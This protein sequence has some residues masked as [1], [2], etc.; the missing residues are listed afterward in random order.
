MADEL[1]QALGDNSEL[2]PNWKAR[3]PTK[4]PAYNLGAWYWQQTESEQPEPPGLVGG[5]L[6]RGSLT[7][8]ADL[9]ATGVLL[10]QGFGLD[11]ISEGF[12]EKAREWQEAASLIPRRVARIEDVKSAGDL[13]VFAAESIVETLPLL[14]SVLIPGGIVGKL[15]GKVA[16]YAAAGLSDVGIH[17]G[18]SALIAQEAGESPAD[19]RVIGSGVGKAALDFIPIIAVLKKLGV[20]AVFDKHITKELWNRGYWKRAAGTAGTIVATE[21]PTE[22]M[23]E[24]IN[25]SLNRSLRDL[26]GQ[27]TAEEK[28]QLLNAGAAAASMGLLGLPLG[29]IRP[30]DQ[31]PNTPDS[32]PPSGTP[33][34]PPPWSAGGGTV[35]DL[36]RTLYET[37]TGRELG[38]QLQADI[39]ARDRAQEIDD[40]VY[41]YLYRA[42]RD[43]DDGSGPGGGFAYSPSEQEA[44]VALEKVRRLMAQG[45]VAQAQLVEQAAK[46]PASV[47]PEELAVTK[48]R[49]EG[50]DE[51]VYGASSNPL[52]F[53][54]RR[55]DIEEGGAHFSLSGGSTYFDPESVDAGYYDLR[56]ANVANT[57]DP[58][59][60][61]RI[62]ER[63]IQNETDVDMLGDLLTELEQL[64]TTREAV[65]T[66]EDMGPDSVLVQ[67][68]KDLGYDGAQF[69][70]NDD[71]P[72]DA[73]TVN[74]WNTKTVR[75]LQPPG[76]DPKEPTLHLDVDY[77]MSEDAGVVHS[78][79]TISST[80][81]GFLL[82]VDGQEAAVTP[83][84]LAAQQLG[85][86]LVDQPVVLKYGD[87]DA[88]AAETTPMEREAQLLKTNGAGPEGQKIIAIDAAHQKTKRPRATKPRK[89][90]TV[91]HD[92]DFDSLV[93]LHAEI[94]A[95]EKS[96]RN[97][98][99][100]KKTVVRQLDNIEARA[101]RLAEVKK[102]PNPLAGAKRQTPEQAEQTRAHSGNL[103]TAEQARL[104]QLYEWEQVRGLSPREYEAL[105]ELIAKRDGEVVAER[106]PATEEAVAEL[107]QDIEAAMLQAEDAFLA[108]LDADM[109]AVGSLDS[110]A[111][112]KP[113]ALED[114]LKVLKAFRGVFKQAPNIILV[115]NVKEFLKRGFKINLSVDTSNMED[116]LL[117]GLYKNG[118]VYIFYGNMR[119]AV[120]MARVLLHETVAHYG[121]RATMSSSDMQGLLDL[122][123]RTRDQDL[124]TWRSNQYL[125]P[126]E[127]NITRAEAEEYIAHLAETDR[128]LSL[129][130]KIVA[131]VRAAWRRLGFEV[132][133]SDNDIRYI[134]GGIRARLKGRVSPRYAASVSNLVTELLGKDQLPSIG[135]PAGTAIGS[136]ES[137]SRVWGAKLGSLF[138]TPLQMAERFNIPGAREYITTVQLW[139]ARKMKLMREPARVAEKWRKLSW[140]SQKHLSE[141]I[142]RITL[143]S[144]DKGRKLEEAELRQIFREE[145]VDEEAQR[146]FGEIQRTFEGNLPLLENGL[147]RAAIIQHTQ[148][149]VKAD[150]L[151]ALYNREAD[152][153]SFIQ[154]VANDPLLANLELGG[155]LAQ[156]EKDMAVLKGRDYF[157]LMRF[158]RYTVTIRDHNNKVEVF[159]AFETQSARDTRLKE[160]RNIY[161]G[162]DI[163]EGYMSDAQH[164]L[165]GFPPALFDLMRR[166]LKLTPAQEEELK[167]IY[168]KHSPGRAYLRHLIERKG[169]AGFS[170]D[171]LRV[172]ATYMMNMANHISRIEFNQEMAGSLDQMDKFAK[173][174]PQ[175]TQAG[176]VADYFSHH[177]D[178]INTPEND[179]AQLRAMGFLWYLG[180]N[181]KS[182]LV[183][184][185]Q[186]PMVA[187]PFFAARY[188]DTAATGALMFGYRTVAA[189]RNGKFLNDVTLDKAIQRGRDEGFLDESI[190]TEL[191]GLAESDVLQRLMPERY[192]GQLLSSVAY[193]GSFLF[194]HAEKLNREV[195][196]IA[197]RKLALERGMSEESAYLSAR[198]AVQATMFEYAKWNRPGF[199]R[200]K[201]SVVFLFWQYMQG[202]S[203]I[204]FGGKG[205]KTALRVWMMLLLAGGLQGLPF[206]ENVMDII[207]IL[208]TELRELFGVSNPKLEVR[209]KLRELAMEITDNPDAIMHG[210]SRY[211]GLGPMHLL[212]NMGIPVPNV[213]ISGSVSAGGMLPGVRPLSQEGSDPDK[214]LAMVM[215]DLL[216]P[217]MS[218]PFNLFKAMESTDPD[219]WKTWERAMPTALASASKAWRRSERG[220]ET[221]RGG[222]AV[223]KFEPNDIDHRMENILQALGF[224]PTRITQRYERRASQE[225]MRKYW[226]VR[227]AAAIENYAYAIMS[228]D[229][230]TLDG[231]L[232]GIRDFNH[233]APAGALRI[234]SE[235]VQKSLSERFR[236]AGQ[237]ER[238]QPNEDAFVPLYSGVE[239]LYPVLE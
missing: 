193:Y 117:K 159:E 131:M 183:N 174:N 143:A 90:R 213:D 88:Q 1:N 179:L 123:K 163:R 120:E 238:G 74:I 71:L 149:P 22:V 166:N 43:D 132:K 91:Q 95:D 121:L 96:Y 222:G 182:A 165:L 3:F 173:S 176:V 118:A 30:V 18:E 64:R 63:A 205:G 69:I 50:A 83:S 26:D 156:I 137:F 223:L 79:A 141:A 186:I 226:T 235:T 116:A 9:A 28:S 13:G 70:E 119:N 93:K 37:V 206:A 158:G 34:A 44:Q 191:A 21:V 39:G 147:K 148:D 189:S 167:E 14:A 85:R 60:M 89:A 65:F 190:A 113:L 224:S 100:L 139:W 66:Y 11:E 171:A 236:R 6:K 194:R 134:L 200:G 175:G 76:Y 48:L 170:R 111:P 62:F 197:A 162:Q 152:H 215:Q 169:I 4:L 234:S 49:W 19:V 218:V 151:L 127:K 237:R 142:F 75:E 52:A 105:E 227:R 124:R 201:K 20:G 68:A 61:I 199:M 98:G 53:A 108:E 27:L 136:M 106:R 232:K 8:G 92:E 130:S 46:S 133:L 103:T 82:S 217:V 140:Q 29:A 32:P 33:P 161:R 72:G 58:D 54:V 110:G 15:G 67:A 109:P 77:G 122:L 138:L 164:V 97:D 146:V 135:D 155:R 144:D 114:A 126:Y 214:K 42:R 196:F 17:V 112:K 178:Y 94:L 212:A 239:R 220:E 233:E 56:G 102:L 81:R 7:V 78:R 125:I 73:T 25:I 145:R 45:D 24:A 195:T 225:D 80:T 47:T 209:D 41:R 157:P 101:A 230:D 115:K 12:Y 229:K 5:A 168:F 221:F 87:A 154:Q 184:L 2:I 16:G 128:D 208:G 192:Q 153:R 185:T 180:F 207:D 210:L 219:T 160:L 129:L 198:E 202:L 172:Y 150:A 104:E 23:Q 203:Y 177:N 36:E 55:G 99:E 51:A 35:P 228:G 107:E 188:G 231:A 204:G 57:Q 31:V 10:A 84:L 181:V 59:T 216:G 187:H 211:Y 86:M 40:Y 38:E